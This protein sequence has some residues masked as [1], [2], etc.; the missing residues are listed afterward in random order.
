MR[1]VLLNVEIF[2]VLSC[3]EIEKRLEITQVFSIVDTTLISRRAQ[4]IR[5]VVTVTTEGKITK[6]RKLQNH[7]NCAKDTITK[8]L[9]KFCFR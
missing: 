9:L 1:R 8:E 4:P 3:Q 2:T 7:K 6:T 5:L